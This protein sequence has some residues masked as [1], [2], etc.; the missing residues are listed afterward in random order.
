MLKCLKKKKKHLEDTL[1]KECL[2]NHSNEKQQRVANQGIHRFTK[3]TCAS[4]PGFPEKRLPQTLSSML[5][6]TAPREERKGIINSSYKK[7]HA[8]GDS[9]CVGLIHT[10][11]FQINQLL[12]GDGSRGLEAGL[13]KVP[14]CEQRP[15]NWLMGGLT[16]EEGREG[17]SPTG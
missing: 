3:D 5:R 8:D 13:A 12:P 14:L 10:T 1:N 11:T 17:D 6:I 15:S 9:G 7:Q 4:S 2:G 16:A